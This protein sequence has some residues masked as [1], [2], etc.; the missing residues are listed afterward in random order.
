MDAL[1]RLSQTFVGTYPADATE[2][3]REYMTNVAFAMMALA[4]AVCTALIFAG[5]LAEAFYFSSITIMLLIDLP[6]G[7]AWWLVRRGYWRQGRYVPLAV[8]LGLGLWGNYSIGL[9]TTFVIFYAMAILLA[10]M[11]CDRKVHWSVLGA[12]ILGYVTVGWARDYGPALDR[13]APAI[14]VVG[15]LIGIALLQRLNANQL[16]HVMKRLRTYAVELRAEVTERARAE[17]ELRRTQA[18]LVRSARMAAVGELAAGVAHELN[19]PLTPVLGLAEFVL[20]KDYLD[21]A[22]RRDLSII[23]A[24]ARRAREIVL[25]LLDFARKTEPNRQQADV[26]Q[27]VRETMALVRSQLEI[28]DIAVEER[29]GPDLP[30]LLLDTTRLKQVWLNLFVNALQAMPHGGRLAVTT[31]WLPVPAGRPGDREV[32]IRIGDTGTGIPPTVLPRIFEPFYTTKP[33]G[34]GTGL[35][36]SVSLGIVQDHGGTIDVDTQQGKGTTFTVWLPAGPQI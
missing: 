4:L 35:G 15:A 24:E 22:A 17:E 13:L 23:V 20:K 11:L 27:T 29:Y 8:F 9:S 33:T 31:E 32:A 16:Q 12:S 36:L 14:P 28:N 6:I 34:Q 30:L 19:N 7:A 5:W 26:N 1:H 25:N 10:G 2:G 18:Q 21:D 3:Q